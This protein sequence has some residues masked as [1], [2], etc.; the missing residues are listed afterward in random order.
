MKQKRKK[1]VIITGT[2]S[3]KSRILKQL[4]P[5]L[6]DFVDIESYAT[7]N[8]NLP[9]I[10]ADLIVIT[11]PLIEPDVA[12]FI[13][14]NSKVLYARRALDFSTIEMLYSIPEGTE[15]L[16]VNDDIETAADVI[17]LI[18]EVGIDHI[19]LIPF[20][21]GAILKKV[22]EIAI[23]P[24]E[25]EYAPAGIEKLI[26]IGPRIIDITTVVEILQTLDL[27]DEKAHYVSAKYFETIVRL[28]KQLY[29]SNTD[30]IRS[31]ENLN[32]VLNQVNDGILAFT[33]DGKITVF[34]QKCEE[35]FKTRYFVAIG[36]EITNIIRDKALTDFM[37]EKFSV[38]DHLLKVGENEYAVS[39]FF[40][41]KLDAYIVTFKSTKEIAEIES[42]MRKNLIKKG[43]I[44]KYNFSDIIYS[45][46]TM[47]KT[48]ETARKI[49]KTDLSTLIY[50]ESGTGKELFSS[51]IHNSSL[52]ES[53]PYLAVNFS[54]LPEELVE[55]EL[56][57]Y[58]E[59]AFTGAKKGGRVGLFE[60]ATGGTIFL[61][62]IGDTSLKIQARL[63]RVLQEK[64][65]MKVG[66]SEIIPINVRVIAATNKDLVKMCQEGKFR[67]DLYYRLKKLSLT[68]PPLRK[69]KEDIEVLIQH[70]IKK[71]NRNDIEL[72]S[73]VLSR[74]TSHHWPG[75]V[76]EL[77]NAVEYMLAVCDGK[78]ICLGNLPQ[79]I[80]QIEENTHKENS[81]FEELHKKGNIDEFIFI[82]KTIETR[83]KRG[84][85]IGR[86]ALSQLSTSLR[87]PLTEEQIRNRTE[88]LAEMDLIVKSRGRGGMRVTIRGFELIN[89]M[90]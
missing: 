47:Y 19:T 63:L 88:I 2:E 44:G 14:P 68:T 86:K 46:E 18:T 81:T 16:V 75:N 42:K 23:T 71:N 7:D 73:E 66:G 70:F 31:N 6:S 61:D 10:K 72:S 65:I 85:G 78:V 59:G 80:Y 40:A 21:P 38:N 4:D 12:P 58:E 27:L 15:V 33:K 83:Q 52:R 79:D 39:R 48:I 22:P 20:Y 55:S 74:L 53:G 41:N 69:S 51:S 25:P 62:E 1:I 13:S 77:E 82:L 60:Q 90:K 56:F 50:G 87:N 36:K 24:G 28:G 45:S 84:V 32:K 3:T 11:S 43:H 17:N 35:I 8:K 30:Q 64:E 9:Q 89:G 67:E 29:Q 37:I 57:G 5:L 76:R 54:A 26:D 34:N 49:A